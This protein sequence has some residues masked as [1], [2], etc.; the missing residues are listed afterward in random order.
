[1]YLGKLGSSHGAGQHV[2]T[3]RPLQF[4]VG[5][6]RDISCPKHLVGR[7]IGRGGETIKAL[8]REHQVNIQIEQNSDPATVKV[9]GPAENV[10]KA[11]EH[12][13]GIIFGTDGNDFGGV[14]SAYGAGAGG[15]THQLR[16]LAMLY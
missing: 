16:A 2:T 12:I 9:M 10:A 8:Q 3:C 4:G 14:A 11:L 1:M 7:I 5:N 6:S 13:G 15:F